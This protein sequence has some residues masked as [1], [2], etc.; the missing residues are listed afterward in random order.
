MDCKFYFYSDTFSQNKM[1]EKGMFQNFT[2]F[3]NNFL[4]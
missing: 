1:F 4:R 3:Y 2:M